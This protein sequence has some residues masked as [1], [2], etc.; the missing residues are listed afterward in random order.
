VTELHAAGMPLGLLPDMDY[1]E[2]E[3]ILGPGDS[4]LLHS[5]GLAEAHSPAGEMFGFP[6]LAKLCGERDGGEALIDLL[7]SELALFTGPAWEQEDDITLVTLQRLAGAAGTVGAAGQRLLDEF[8][9]SS[10]P[11]TERAAVE[12]VARAVAELDLS[13]SRMERL[14]T[15]VGEG[16]MNAAEHGNQGRPELPVAIRV[17]ASATELEVAVTDQGGDQPIPE[18]PQPD[19]EAK[20]AGAQGPRGWGLFLIRNM[21]DDLRTS[22]DELHHT[23]HLIVHLGGTREGREAGDDND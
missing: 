5:D 16:V 20:L 15:A 8:E 9:V 18:A 23:V 10:E 1:Q 19:L 6:R 2:H 7:L 22:G 17:T 4:L 21:V 11:G 12:R 13:A 14:K 3:T